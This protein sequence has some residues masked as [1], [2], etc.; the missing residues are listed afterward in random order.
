MS[1]KGLQLAARREALIDQVAY[2]RLQLAEA[3]EPLSSPIKLA[4]RGLSTL[5]YLTQHPLILAGSLA[6]GVA[7]RPNRWVKAL[8]S[9]WLVWR[10]A[11]AAKR[12]L[13]E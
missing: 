13:D 1:K 4:D 5:R 8:E 9:G 6:L 10:I 2:Q 3:Y 7:V 12:S 11:L